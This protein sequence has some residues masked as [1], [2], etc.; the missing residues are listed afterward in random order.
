MLQYISTNDILYPHYDG[1]LV[2]QEFYQKHGKQIQEFISGAINMGI[3]NGAPHYLLT[4]KTNIIDQAIFAPVTFEHNGITYKCLA[5]LEEIK[6][7]ADQK[8]KFINDPGALEIFRE[9]IF[10][11]INFSNFPN[12]VEISPMLNPV[13]APAQPEPELKLIIE[14]AFIIIRKKRQN[15]QRQAIQINNSAC[16]AH[17]NRVSN[18]LILF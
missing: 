6:N 16:Q 17:G 3:K 9:N 12:L 11:K 14:V 10:K 13:I 15:R 5:F 18:C 7:Q 1:L 4:L 2:T 8:S